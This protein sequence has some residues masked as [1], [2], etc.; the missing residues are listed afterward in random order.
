VKH[1]SNAGQTLV[2][3]WSNSSQTL[4]K[5]WSNAG[6]I[7]VKRWS[8]PDGPG[9]RQG[10]H[11]SGITGLDVCVRKPLVGDALV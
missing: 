9:P 5:H 3:R 10:F 7:P 4:V 2:K 1:W 8:N 11:S 6:K